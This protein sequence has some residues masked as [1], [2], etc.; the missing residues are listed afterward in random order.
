MN[1]FRTRKHRYRIS[2]QYVDDNVNRIGET[3]QLVINRDTVYMFLAA[4]SP[5]KCETYMN[6][7]DSLKRGCYVD[8]TEK[9]V[10]DGI[11]IVKNI[12]IERN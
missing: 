9:Q 10:E 11:R 4:F 7:I 6:T 5:I 12:R 8:I 1:I 3:E 2:V